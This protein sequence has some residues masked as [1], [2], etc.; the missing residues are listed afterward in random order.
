[1]YRCKY[2]GRYL[3]SSYDNCPGCGSNS[4][5]YVNSVGVMKIEE[6]PKDGYKVNVKNLKTNRWSGL[7]LT[8]LGGGMLFGSLI[9]IIITGFVGGVL[10]AY[11]VVDEYGEIMSKKE[12]FSNTSTSIWAFGVFGIIMLV[13]GIPLLIF[14]IRTMR[15]H[16][17]Q[18]KD[19]QTL[20]HKGLLIKNLPYRIIDS[21]TR[22]NDQP[23]YCIEIVYETENGTKIPL[24]S[25]PKY[26]GKLTRGDDTVDLLIDP[27]NPSNYF[28]DFEIY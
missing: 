7:A 13:I 8:L 5:E 21:G 27:E 19:A 12:V 25:E 16:S 3:K 23:I 9:D 2:C 11:P 26:D 14:G 28:I 6:I 20:A 15:K 18:I 1:M 10:L 4:Y 17:K 24:Q 22:V